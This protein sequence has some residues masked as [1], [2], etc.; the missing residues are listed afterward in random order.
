MSR[1]DSKTRKRWLAEAKSEDPK[2]DATQT[3]ISNWAGWDPKPAIDQA[4]ASGN[5]ETIY[6]TVNRGAYGPFESRVINASHFGLGIVKDVDFNVLPKRL[7]E[8][9]LQKSWETIPEQW[10][11]IDIGE[12]ARYGFDF[13]KR[14]ALVPREELITLFSGDDKFHHDGDVLDRTFCALRVWAVVRPDE[15]RT[16]IATIKDAEMRKALTWLLNNPWGTEP[17]E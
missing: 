13:V 1:L 10:G 17:N 16:W 7:R 15:M 11:D 6:A 4:I 14:Y 8:E 9:V 2:E 3:L 12:T 5:A